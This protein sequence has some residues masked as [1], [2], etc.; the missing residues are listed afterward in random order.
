MV[1][2]EIKIKACQDFGTY[3]SHWAIKLYLIGLV[4]QEDYER[5]NNRPVDRN[6]F[7]ENLIFSTA[8]WKWRPMAYVANLQK[9]FSFV[10]HLRIF[11][12]CFHRGLPET[13]FW[14]YFFPFQY[15]PTNCFHDSLQV[16]RMATYR[17]WWYN[18]WYNKVWPPDDEH[19][20]ARNM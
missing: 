6:T 4:I 2:I 19:N 15:K 8:L 12:V 3:I 16:H 5:K 10:Y 20:I 13:K 11:R 18:L 7:K 9:Q 17:V 14:L 1:K